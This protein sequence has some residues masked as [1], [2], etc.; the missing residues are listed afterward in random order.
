MSVSEGMDV[1]RVRSI[2][3]QLGRSSE[4]I[5][6]VHGDGTGS[7]RVLDGVWAGPD[8]E[9]F[10]RGWDA[11]ASSLESAAAALA[12]LQRDLLRQAQDQDSA[13][14][15]G[16]G[17]GG[18]G[19]GPADDRGR[20]PR[21]VIED[22]FDDLFDGDGDDGG[23]G[24]SL[25]NP[26]DGLRD[27][28]DR[29]T[30]AVEDAW[31]WAGDRG[32]DL[33]EWGRDGLDWLGDRGRDLVDAGRNFWDEQ[34]VT[35]WDAGMAALARLGPSIVNFGEQFTQIFTE[36]RWPRFHE[37]AASAI[38]LL[39]RT[40]GLFANIATGED[41]QIFD[42]GDGVVTSA[43]SVEADPEVAGRIPTD[44]NALMQIQN[45]TYDNTEGREGDNRHVRVTE[46]R[47]P[48]GSSAYIVTVP[49]TNGLFDF[50]G[51]VTGGDE[52]FDNTSNLE[53]QAG[54]RSASMEAVEAAMEEAGIPPG[55]PVMLQ[56]HSQGGMVTGE[57]VQDPAFME[58]YNVTHMITQGSPND[59]RSIPSGVQTLALEHT[60]DPVPK[61]DFGDS[62]AGPPMPIPLPGPL[63][64]VVAPMTPIPNF[65]PALAGSGDH[66]TQVRMEPGPG[67]SMFGGGND[68]AH[69]YRNYSDSVERE[70]AA[71]N[72]GIV[73]Y[74][75]SPGI[76]VFLTGDEGA[77]TITEYGTGRE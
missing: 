30:E 5:R 23:G 36:G 18:S 75:D 15:D 6:G 59:S 58:R 53:L 68:S 76:D 27:A 44:L 72:P 32:R 7:M 67:V 63:P 71:G 52:A 70:I 14:G 50:P 26:V 54:Q 33:V 60:N 16:S 37:V 9:T 74:A 1:E 34:V 21:E 10:S 13:S 29:G 45:D 48:D 46:V 61:V 8:L 64:T 65:D 56:G 25:P 20:D 66:V 12:G 69:H 51:S 31:D 73:D 39:G 19:G 42:S 28:W 49:G 38:L 55:A 4:R 43:N 17:G 2:A 11:G 62:L 47:Q 3:A 35:R 77:V 24:W 22:F 40:G 57:L 41:H